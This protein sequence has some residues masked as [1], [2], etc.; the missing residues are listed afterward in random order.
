[1]SKVKRAIF[2]PKKLFGKL[3]CQK[4]NESR[5]HNVKQLCDYKVCTEYEIE[6]CQSPGIAYGPK[7]CRESGPSG[8]IG[9]NSV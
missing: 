6:D 4:H 5:K 9:I 8:V 3:V 7:G 2:F 1:M